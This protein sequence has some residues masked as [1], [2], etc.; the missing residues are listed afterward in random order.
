[1]LQTKYDS[2]GLNNL[3]IAVMEQAYEDAALKMPTVKFKP[4][5]RTYNTKAMRRIKDRANLIAEANAFITATRE[6]F[7]N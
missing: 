5:N 4:N 6:A 1:M 3:V 2:D 7:S